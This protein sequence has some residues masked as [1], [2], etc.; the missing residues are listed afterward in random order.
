MAEKGT[1]VCPETLSVEYGSNRIPEG[2]TVKNTYDITVS[3]IGWASMYVNVPLTIP[4]GVEVYYASAAEGNVVTLT[5]FDKEEMAPRTAVIVRATPGTVQFPLLGNEGQSVSGNLFA[6]TSVDMGYE[7]GSVY[8]LSRVNANG[9]P[10]FK[11]YTG[12][13]LG[14]NKAYLP[15]SVVGDDAAG[16][17]S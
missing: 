4:E 10:Q 3:E 9:N 7:P 6:G 13:T 5:K 8:V 11:N 17:T 16:S 1:F 15:K 2:W 14:A 12:A